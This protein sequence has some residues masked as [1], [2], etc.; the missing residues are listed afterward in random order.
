M[1]DDPWEAAMRA[2]GHTPVLY[3]FGSLDHFVMES[4]FHNGPGCSVCGWSCCEH[5][6]SVSDIPECEGPPPP[7]PPVRVIRHADGSYTLARTGAP[8]IIEEETKS[9]G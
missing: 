3:S 2:K 8:V 9:D 1:N 6:D 4:G 5:C 7:G